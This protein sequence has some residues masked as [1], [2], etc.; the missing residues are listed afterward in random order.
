MR[1]CK[2]EIQ[3]FKYNYQ[4]S[5]FFNHNL[6]TFLYFNPYHDSEKKVRKHIYQRT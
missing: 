3:F 4:K 5:Y 1:S 2:I 6:L